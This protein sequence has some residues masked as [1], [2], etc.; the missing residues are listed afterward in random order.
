MRGDSGDRW[1][2]AGIALTR[3]VAAEVGSGFVFEFLGDRHP[4][5]EVIR[6]ADSPT[7][8]RAAVLFERMAFEA[9]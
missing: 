2:D 5:M 1:R 4:A 8:A 7:N 9:Q 3:R 6:S